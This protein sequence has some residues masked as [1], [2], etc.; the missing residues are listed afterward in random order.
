ME[1]RPVEPAHEDLPRSGADA[2]RCPRPDTKGVSR[3]DDLDAQSPISASSQA[4]RVSTASFL[5]VKGLLGLSKPRGA[6]LGEELGD[7]EAALLSARSLAVR[8]PGRR[9]DGRFARAWRGGKAPRSLRQEE[10]LLFETGGTPR[11][12]PRGFSTKR[13][14][15]SLEIGL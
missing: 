12:P 13:E 15:T 4:R 2:R 14:R 1:L 10:F 7:R 3:L 6:V 11:L 9:L 8:V 5:V